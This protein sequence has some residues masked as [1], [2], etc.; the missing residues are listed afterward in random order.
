MQL[1][2]VALL[3]DV[4]D[5]RREH[6]GVAGELFVD[7]VGDPVRG[8]A[9]LRRR[10]DVGH[11]R[12]LRLLDGVDEREAHFHAAVA[13]RPHRPDHDGIRAARAEVGEL[14]VLGA[15]RPRHDAGIA[16]LPEEAAPLQIGGDDAGDAERPGRLVLERDDRDRDRRAGAADDFDG[17]LR[18]RRRDEQDKEREDGENQAAQ[19][20]PWRRVRDADYNGAAAS[21]RVNATASSHDDMTR[22]QWTAIV[23]G[24]PSASRRRSAVRVASSR[25]G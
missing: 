12:Q 9:E 18:A 10:D 16:H 19:C 23:D 21:Q 15:A 24:N 17:E 20:G 2:A 3:R 1:E 4:G 13:Q 8:G 11:R 14:H 25:V 22:P 6:A 7:D 5:A